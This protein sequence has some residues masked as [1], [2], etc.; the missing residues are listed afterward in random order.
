MAVA[1]QSGFLLVALTTAGI[2][3]YAFHVVIARQLPPEQYG[4]LGAAL[5]FLVWSSIPLGA[6][7]AAVAKGVAEHRAG[8][9]SGCDHIFLPNLRTVLFIAGAASVTLCL[10]SPLLR[11]FLH[12]DSLLTT[13]FVAL[14][15]LPASCLAVLRG[16]LQGRMQFA[17]LALVSLI[18]TLVRLSAGVS[19][20][21]AGAGVPGAVASST[22]GELVGVLLGVVLLPGALRLARR[23][24][25]REEAER[26]LIVEAAPLAVGLGGMWL[27]IQLDLLLARPLLGHDASGDYAAAALLARAVLFV[28]AAV[29]LVALPLFSRS[30]WHRERAFS[31]L[32]AS[33]AVTAALCLPIALSFT[34]FSD[35]VI[36]W[37][38]GPGFAG[39]ASLLPPMAIGMT[40][41][42]VA[43]LLLFFHVAVGSRAFY[44]LWPLALVEG[45]IL[46][47]V[48]PS[49]Q[50]LAALIAAG[51]WAV[52]AAGLLMARAITRSQANDERLPEV[53]MVP[54]TARAVTHEIP[55]ISIV[56]PLC[57][58]ETSALPSVRAVRSALDLLGRP[59]EVIVIAD[60]DAV[61]G[62]AGLEELTRYAD[63]F[64]YAVRE[65]KGTALRL[66]LA[67]AQGRYV[68]FIDADGDI[69][70]A[71]L[72]EFMLIM[73][74][75]RPH[76][77]MGSKRH[78][79]SVVDYPLTR[80]VMSRSY[81]AMVRLL[82][83]L[84][85]TD[86]Q[87]G[88][89]LIQKDV[90]EAVL[91]RMLE[92]RFAF[93]LE[94]LVV[95]KKLGFERFLEAPVRLTYRFRSTVAPRDVYRIT[96]DT[97]ALFYRRSILRTYDHSA[98]GG[99]RLPS[100][101]G[102]ALA[103]EGSDA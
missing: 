6:V 85:V 16:T 100:T 98:D 65:G 102:P 78:P 4:A 81:Q 33:T 22:L 83:G 13:V 57:D 95:A 9:V 72:V 71:C 58:G 63:V 26:S 97:L 53:C 45:I 3:N 50:S 5:A 101:P 40:G 14:Y 47:R 68:A 69:D 79:R 32:L 11:A 41:L 12:L 8:P 1:R 60:G 96:L 36:A 64:H 20:V 17:S 59:Y 18:P 92:K 86:T 89:K 27:I 103:A 54:S 37:S 2:S 67:R 29:S 43:N 24:F 51:G 35:E 31:W 99:T 44:L 38:F 61:R 74:R 55:E 82:F 90:L 56:M 19:L 52:A 76:L 46:F 48:G 66:G 88:I 39:A 70:A 94:L 91:P 62:N 75:D 49:P 10:A 30:K 25:R 42:A 77:V 80:R 73:D 34:M 28:P 93:D 15:L 7:Q 21:R 84:N 23:A 87:T